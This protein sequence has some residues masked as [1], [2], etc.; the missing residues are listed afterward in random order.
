MSLNELDLVKSEVKDLTLFITNC[1][2]EDI[3]PLDELKEIEDSL[4]ELYD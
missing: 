2:P 4:D 3:I 1:P